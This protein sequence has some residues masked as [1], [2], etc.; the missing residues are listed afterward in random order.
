MFVEL[1]FD[2]VFV[3]SV[4]QVVGLL[5]HEFNWTG[6]GQAVLVF[7]L[8]WWAW[9]QF[10][11]ALNA[12][13]TEH[14]HIQFWTLATTAVAFFMAVALPDA[15]HGGSLAFAIPYVLVRVIGLSLYS[16]VAWEHPTQR[17]AVRTF[18][19]VSVGGLAAVIAG[20]IVGGMAQYGLWGFAILLDVVAAA[21]ATQQD[22]WDLNPEHFG[23]RHGLFVII[24]LGE[25]LIVAA[26]GLAGAA[27]TGTTITVAMLAVATSCALWWTYFPNSKPTLEEALAKQ[28][29]V[30]QATM[31]RD[32]FSLMHFPMLCGVIAYAVAI[33]AIVTHPTDPLSFGGRLALALGLVLFVGGMAAAMWRATCGRLVPRVLIVTVTGLLVVVVGGVPPLASLAIAFAGVAAIALIEHRAD[34]C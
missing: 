8:V 33:E 25:T 15:F 24:A 10:T 1:F 2:L 11:W 18:A 12:A 17:M 7:W 3:Y 30:T 13:N 4:T 5:H 6:V 32:V 22:G 26:G 20:G 31:A 9:S 19:L 28:T 29:G 14:H 27:W 16:W 34:P 23:E 21:I